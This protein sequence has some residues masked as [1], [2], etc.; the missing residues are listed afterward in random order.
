MEE[1]K[2]S[3]IPSLLEE[4]KTVWEKINSIKSKSV[5]FNKSDLRVIKNAF[6]AAA[7]YEAMSERWQRAYEACDGG[8]SVAHDDLKKAVEIMG[9]VTDATKNTKRKQRNARVDH[10]IYE[11]YTRFDA[12]YFKG[13]DGLYYDDEGNAGEMIEDYRKKIIV[14]LAKKFYFA[15][16]RA[17]T[18]YLRKTFGFKNLPEFRDNTK[19]QGLS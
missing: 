7:N 12:F 19:N 2:F 16:P 15:S 4:I 11:Y 14:R 5:K 1:T 8:N 17:A 10:E 9:L 13:E 3:K 6:V 18:E